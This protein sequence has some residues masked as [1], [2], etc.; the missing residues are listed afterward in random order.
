MKIIHCCLAS[1]YI[2]NHSY[3]ENILPKIHKQ[4]GYDVKIVASTETWIDNKN[5]GYVKSSSYKNEDSIPVTRIDYVKWLPHA[6]SKKLRIY[7]GLSKILNDFKPDI[8]FLH[9]VQ[10]ISI[11]EVIKYMDKY[12]KVILFADGHTDFINSART[13]LSKN[14]LHKVIYKYCAQRIEPYA[15]KFWGVTPSRVDFYIDVYGINKNK[16]D[17]LVMGVDESVIDFKNKLSIRKDIRNELGI[18]QDTFTIITGGKIEKNKNIHFLMRAITELGLDN[19]NLI[20]FGSADDKMKS[21]I[22]ELSKSN[23]IK[24]IGWISSKEVY[25]Y[26]FASDLAFF[27]GT[28]SVLW[29]QAVGIGL[30]CVFKRWKGMEHVD[31]GGN[32]IFLKE[33]SLEEI[34]T[35]ISKI[36]NEKKLYSNMLKVASGKGVSEFSYLKIAKKSIQIDTKKIN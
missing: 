28:H 29:E 2:D 7:N 32:C 27:P 19:I 6:I 36:N 18:S 13:W 23:R 25:K 24:N 26:Y 8:I 5:L 34:K 4:L 16:V 15:Q 35:T 20:V 1:Y 30:P 11:I 14:I 10:F 3:Q 31:V 33:G 9:D 21:E 12:E 22:I 17:L